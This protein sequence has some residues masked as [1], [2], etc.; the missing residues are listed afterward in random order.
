MMK[1]AR[2]VEILKSINVAL[3]KTDSDDKQELAY[4]SCIFETAIEHLPS[5]TPE[6]IALEFSRTRKLLFDI[7]MRRTKHPQSD[8]LY[9]KEIINVLIETVSSTDTEAEKTLKAKAKARQAA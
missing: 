9:A 2:L 8:F 7:A 3:E 1:N 4:Q 5:E 6:K